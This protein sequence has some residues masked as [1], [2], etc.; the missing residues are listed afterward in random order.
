MKKILPVLPNIYFANSI[1]FYEKNSMSDEAYNEK[2]FLLL[3][4]FYTLFLL[5]DCT[6][7]KHILI[8]IFRNAKDIKFL[9]LDK[10]LF[11]REIND[12]IKLCNT[13]TFLKRINVI[14]YFYEAYGTANNIDDLDRIFI[15]DARIANLIQTNNISVFK[16]LLPYMSSFMYRTLRNDTYSIHNKNNIPSDTRQSEEFELLFGQYKISFLPMKHID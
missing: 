14:I 1:K 9:S 8:Y 10:N 3:D 11:F 2:S 16:S 5:L 6:I 15:Y 4:L 12:S 13:K 7:P